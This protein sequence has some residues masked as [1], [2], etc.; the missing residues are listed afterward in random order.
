MKFKEI[1]LPL[2]CQSLEDLSLD[3]DAEEADGLMGVWSAPFHPAVLASVGNTPKWVRAEQPPEVD[4]RLD[5]DPAL[6]DPRDA[7]ADLVADLLAVGFCYLQVELTT[8]QLRYMSS[9]DSERL[10]GAAVRAAEAIMH[11]DEETARESIQRAFDTLTEAR[12]YFYPVEAKL[13]DLTLVAP[14]TL[15]EP[16][17][18]ELAGP[19]ASNLLISGGT[20]AE[21]AR[22]EPESLAAL[23][24]ALDGSTA[25]IVGGE[26]G[27]EALPLLAPESILADLHRGLASYEDHLGHRPTIFARRRF[28]LSPVLPGI[29]KKLGFK[30]ACHFTLDAGRFPTGNQSKVRWEGLD[31]AS[32]ESLARVPLDASR[33]DT[34]L[35]MP[36]RLGRVMDLDH[37]ATAVFAHWP[38]KSSRWYG[39]LRRTA[40]YSPVLGRFVTIDKYF[41]DTS[42]S[43]QVARHGP[44]DYR[45]PYLVEAV[46]AAQRDPISRWVRYHRRRVHLDV[47]GALDCLGT[48]LD[49]PAESPP[50]A[51]GMA[52][53]T[54]QLLAEP[55]EAARVETDLDARIAEGIDGSLRRIAH[56]LPRETKPPEPGHVLVNPLS[57]STA[58]YL[59]AAGGSES[60][61]QARVEVPAMGFAWAGPETRPPDPGP[62]TRKK[63]F[64]SRRPQE[65]PP[66]A[67]RTEEGLYMLRN[68]FFEATIDPTTG[69]IRAVHDYRTRGN[70]L[71]QQIALRMPDSRSNSRDS[72]D[73]EDQEQDYSVMAA[74]EVRVDAP[75]P[76]LGRITSRGRLVD[77]EGKRLA[78]FVETMTARRGSRVL[79]IE[80]ELAPERVPVASPWNSYYAA[81]FAWHDSTAEL[82]RSVGMMRV[83]TE[84]PRIEAPHFVDVRSERVRTTIL[85]GGLPYHRR[86]GPRRMDTLL[87]VRGETSRRFRLGVGVDLPYPVPAA[88]EFL[89]PRTVLAEMAAPLSAASGW[90]F[91]VDARNVVATH[92]EP[93]I[94][95]GRAAGFVARLLETEGRKT[96]LGLRSF[97]E[98]TAAEET[99]FTGQGSQ[100]LPFQGDRVTVELAAHEWVEVRVRW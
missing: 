58:C 12:E 42:G 79:E 4:E 27:E 64:W 7:N 11:G 50:D 98:V 59:D 62:A 8:R 73:E 91:H 90:L 29:L 6:V 38:G 93:I 30:G 77:H 26:F 82:H 80:I 51:R 56:A 71:A 67:E 10:R 44:D 72:G 48:M 31:A 33:H 66:L 39:D 97:R 70:R 68:E 81:R 74:D 17:R 92:W 76:T 2:P 18:R 95:E 96:T 75:G 60:P 16:L 14:T 9:L 15:G 23:R 52:R 35:K 46:E 86:F 32:L 13:L 100:S 94:A 65:E 3:R 5:P 28:G 69:A 24:A 55:A 61:A 84:A 43:G 20:V 34:F 40:R 25:S 47:S 36:E 88:I 45:S 54:E 1:I 85:T 37:T 53:Q 83:A 78:G 99:D 49:G 21:M 87:V 63:S 22:R 19:G 57:F 41:E 89:A